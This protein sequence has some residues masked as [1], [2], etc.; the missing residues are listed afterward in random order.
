MGRCGCNLAFQRTTLHEARVMRP[1]ARPGFQGCLTQFGS[2]MSM[3]S[4]DVLGFGT[5][6]WWD[7][8]DT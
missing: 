3:L 4:P 7:A 6:E 1:Q 2:E 8:E 5:S